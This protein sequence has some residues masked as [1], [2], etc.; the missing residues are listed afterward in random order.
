MEPILLTPAPEDAG[1]RIDCFL[2]SHLD[3]V[4]R[5]AAQKLLEGGAVQVNGKAVAKNYKLTGREPLSITLPEAEEA[6]LIPQDIPLDVVYEDADVI[7]VNKPSG[8][9]VHPAPGHSDGTLVN[10]LLYHCGNSLSGVGGEK[11]PGIVHRID[12]DTSGLIIAAKNADAKDA[13][14]LRLEVCKESADLL[15]HLS[16]LWEAAGVS[17][18]DVMAVLEERSH[19]KGNKKTVGHLDKTF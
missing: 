12:R 19:V 18:N 4:T 11:R 2:A 10:A 8:L 17:V 1:T 16:V 15:Y 7:V 13:E 5:S 9:V 6:D 14:D 3:G